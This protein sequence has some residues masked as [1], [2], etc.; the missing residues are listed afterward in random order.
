MILEQCLSR[1]QFEHLIPHV[2]SMALIDTVESWSEQHI[3]CRTGTH[4]NVENPLRL[5]GAL[6]AIHLLEYGAQAMAIHGGLLSGKAS[7]GFLAAVRG[8]HFYV[9]RLDDIPGELNVQA[10]AEL[11]IQNGA[12]YQFRVTD[13]NNTVLIDARATVIY[14]L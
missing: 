4:Q 8:A 7:P 12:V 5:D 1:G 11:K 10:D 14:K 3:I 6:S 13:S 9:T 2:G